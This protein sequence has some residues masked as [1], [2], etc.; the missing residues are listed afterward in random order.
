MLR[1]HSALLRIGGWGTRWCIWK[2]A[3]G[4]V[5]WG[6]APAA[7]STTGPSHAAIKIAEQQIPGPTAGE[8]RRTNRSLVAQ[9]STSRISHSPPHKNV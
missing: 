9:L 7:P 3:F 4:D 5:R 8:K 1:R 6:S 2:K